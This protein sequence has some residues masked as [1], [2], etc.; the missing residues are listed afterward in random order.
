MCR[1]L[2][3]DN[4]DLLNETKHISTKPPVLVFILS[5]NE[6][7]QPNIELNFEGLR[8]KNTEP[9]YYHCDH[10]VFT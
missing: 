10:G 3:V 2:Q 5:A 6:I 1:S 9:V 8:H 7:L 4:L